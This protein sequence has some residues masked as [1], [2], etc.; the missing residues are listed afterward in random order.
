MMSLVPSPTPDITFG[1]VRVVKSAD[2]LTVLGIVIEGGMPHHDFGIGGIKKAF[3]VR[4]FGGME[5][6]KEMPTVI[7]AE[8]RKACSR[9]KGLGFH[10]DNGWSKVIFS[11]DHYAAY[12]RALPDDAE[13]GALY[14]SFDR[15]NFAVMS[16]ND[17]SSVTH[18][19]MGLLENKDVV[20]F[21]TGEDNKLGN[22]HLAIFCFSAL[23]ATMKNHFLQE[24]EAFL[25]ARDRWLDGMAKLHGNSVMKFRTSK[26]VGD[27]MMSSQKLLKL[28]KG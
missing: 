5:V 21:L 12:Q 19:I 13:Q 1:R 8:S 23:L 15:G 14:G 4:D 26:K 20:F 3:G 22:A 27:R 2:G 25:Q 6:T 11:E 9:P 16:L 18:R 28:I 7:G 10:Y 24:D 17:M